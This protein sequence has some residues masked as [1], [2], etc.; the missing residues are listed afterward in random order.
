MYDRYALL[1]PPPE[2]YEIEPASMTQVL[3]ARNGRWVEISDDVGSVAAD[4]KR[5]DHHLRVKWSGAGEYFVVYYQHGDPCA[6]C[7][8]SPCAPDKRDLVLTAQELDQRIV[9]RIELIDQHGTSGYDL[10]KEIERQEAEQDKP[11]KFTDEQRDNIERKVH[12]LRRVADQS[13]RIVVP[14]HVA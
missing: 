10:V 6:D 11:L 12:A 4:L 7:T 8:M 3:A 2:S 13:S 1:Q 9:K 14:A 5:I